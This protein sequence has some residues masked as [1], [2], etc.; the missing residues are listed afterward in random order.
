MYEKQ[1]S[2]TFLNWKKTRF[3]SIHLSIV[4][5][6]K[7]IPSSG[8]VHV[9]SNQS[10]MF[11]IVFPEIS[12]SNLKIF[13]K[14]STFSI[15]G[16]ILFTLKHFFCNLYCFSPVSSQLLCRLYFVF[17]ILTFQVADLTLF[18]NKANSH[19][20][21]VKEWEMFLLFISTNSPC[22]DTIL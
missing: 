6:I 17:L 5:I 3:D 10:S 9:F 18:P 15:K 2:G 11:L 13:T 19:Y 21:P 20:N 4:Y 22:K 8:L 16:Q 7:S 14:Q 1:N 12:Y